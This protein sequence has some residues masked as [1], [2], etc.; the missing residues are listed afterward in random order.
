[1]FYEYTVQDGDTLSKIAKRYYGDVS[2]YK[3]LAEFNRIAD[4]DLIKIGQKIDL[5]HYFAKFEKTVIECNKPVICLSPCLAKNDVSSEMHDIELWVNSG[6]DIR[7]VKGN[8]TL[9]IVP[10]LKKSR[11][12]EC[13][14]TNGAAMKWLSSGYHTAEI[15]GPVLK[16]NISSWGHNP[17]NLKPWF[18]NDNP[19][20]CTIKARCE[21]GLEKSA[22]LEVYRGNEVSHEIDFSKSPFCK[23]LKQ[24]FD[25]LDELIKELTGHVI[26]I[27]FAVGTI[28]YKAGFKE[29]QRRPEVFFGYKFNGG[30]NPVFSV[31]YKYPFG[32]NKIMPGPLKRFGDSLKFF[33]FVGG[34]FNLN[35]NYYRDS[36]DNKGAELEAEFS[37]QFGIEG[38]ASIKFGNRK[39]LDAK[40]QGDSGVGSNFGP[41]VDQKGLGITTN[42]WWDGISIKGHILAFDGMYKYK[43][44]ITLI[45]KKNLLRNGMFY[46]VE[47]DEEPN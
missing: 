1:M 10:S 29:A 30:L 4:P 2:Y 40:L 26:E 8:G 15:S 39:I 35:F 43:K 11:T 17:V 22:V 42:M 9:G 3:D 36:I 18:P 7:K 41:V 16:S 38:S 21:N 33:L 28:A 23:G 5:P 25:E 24:V 46:F 37:L 12:I 32:L 45:D 47:F 20:I 27:R 19:R 44:S 34:A 31:T 6:A 14:S 13:R